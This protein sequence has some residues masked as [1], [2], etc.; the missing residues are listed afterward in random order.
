MCACILLH[1]PWSMLSCGL[2]SCSRSTSGRTIEAP[3]AQLA[4]QRVYPTAPRASANSDNANE[5]VFVDC[6]YTCTEYLRRKHP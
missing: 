3:S 2:I 6:L 5:H 1:S 4:A